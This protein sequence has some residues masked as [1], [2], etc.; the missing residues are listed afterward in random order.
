MQL[1]GRSRQQI[2]CGSRARQA[3]RHWPTPA[4]KVTPLTRLLSSQLAVKDHLIT[5]A[6]ALYPGLSAT[7]PSEVASNLSVL[8]SLAPAKQVR[9]LVLS[10][11]QL[12]TLPLESWVDFFSHYGLSTSEF[13]RLLCSNPSVLL[14][15]SVFSAGRA[16][17]FLK[18]LGWTELEISTIM[19]P[20]HA[21]ILQMDVEKQLLP[22]FNHLV[23]DK[24][25][26]P[27][28]AQAYLH[29]HPQLLYTK[30]F[31]AVIQQQLRRERMKHLQHSL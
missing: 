26:L 23:Q 12:L 10:N 22:V 6:L 5:G 4:R 25:L 18:T 8:G 13:W 14:H 19:I 30:N 21:V 2:V 31:K 11:P 24:G 29:Q 20:F 7:T 9:S 17:M 1:C 16:I 28:A 3:R 27:E 15:G